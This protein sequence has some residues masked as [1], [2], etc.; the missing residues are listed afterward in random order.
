MREKRK[1][2]EKKRERTKGIKSGLTRRGVL[3]RH[4]VL[5]VPELRLE[6]G[7]DEVALHLALVVAGP[8]V[9]IALHLDE[10]LEDVLQAHE[11]GEV[12]VLL[13]LAVPGQ[14]LGAP[15]ELRTVS[16]SGGPAP[17]RREP[18]VVIVVVQHRRIGGERRWRWGWS[19]LTPTYA[20]MP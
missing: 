20:D 9:E 10:L 3:P 12:A 5:E 14:R 7:T 8:A 1:K 16:E 6:P 17:R 2:K 15:R 13:Q 18:V 11:P 4:L 19:G